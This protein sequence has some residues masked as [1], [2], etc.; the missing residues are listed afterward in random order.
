MSDFGLAKMATGAPPASVG[1]PDVPGDN[2]IPS[3][4]LTVPGG[5]IGTPSYMAPEQAEGRADVD[6]RADVYGLGAALYDMLT[7]RPPFE[8]KTNEEIYT[9]VENDP[10]APRDGSGR[11]SCAIWR[12]FA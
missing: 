7:G 5:R 3:S 10:P 4:D 11:R 2:L 12:P 8:G 9:K 1:A 6:H